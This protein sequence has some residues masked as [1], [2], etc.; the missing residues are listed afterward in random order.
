MVTSDFD[1]SEPDILEG[2]DWGLK[3]LGAENLLQ[4]R[5][6]KRPGEIVEITSDYRSV[7]VQYREN[8]KGSGFLSF[9]RNSAAYDIKFESFT[10]FDFVTAMKLEKMRRDGR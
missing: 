4:R 6:G 1:S 8:F 7:T 2:S 3:C 10:R 5:L 9:L